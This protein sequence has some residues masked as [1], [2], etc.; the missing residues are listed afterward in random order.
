MSCYMKI[1]DWKGNVTAKGYKDWIEVFHTDFTI[2]QPVSMSVGSGNN[3]SHSHPS[4]SY[5]TLTKRTDSS[6]SDFF[7]SS[8]TGKTLSEVQ[9]HSCHGSEKI[10]PHVK[11][12]LRDA[13][14]TH[15]E[16]SLNTHGMPIE[17]IQISYNSIE[18]HFIGQDEK[19]NT[20]APQITGYKLNTAE[21][22]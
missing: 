15:Y 2:K 13:F 18:K 21:M 16:Q 10:V 9:I 19:G 12:I 17:V 7:H 8:L 1:D 14:V 5:M 6:T 11:Y 22:M 4:L 20:I 3:R